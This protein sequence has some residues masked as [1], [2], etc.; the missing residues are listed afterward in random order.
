MYQ[1]MKLWDGMFVCDPS[2]DLALWVCVAM[3]IRIRQQ[4]EQT[5]VSRLNNA[6][7]I[8]NSARC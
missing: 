5:M 1:S 3:L 7:I 4:C 8:D 6:F 2:M